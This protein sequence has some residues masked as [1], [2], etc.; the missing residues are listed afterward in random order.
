MNIPNILTIIRMA[1]IPVFVSFYFIGMPYWYGWAA[2]I[3]VIASFTDW[4]DGYLARKWN[5]VS[6]FG[7]FMDPI[8]DK[9]LVLAA[10]LVLLVW[11]KLGEEAGLFNGIGLLTVL[12][13]LS[14]E[15][16]VSGFRLVAASRGVVIAADKSGKIKTVVQMVALIL[17]LF[18]GL[19]FG[20]IGI[21][22]GLILIYASVIISVYSCIEYIVKNKKVFKE[23][24]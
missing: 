19:L 2:L 24:E 21:C 1:L 8:A 9:L 18:N 7:K 23:S 15:F 13:L 6:N 12:I 5:Q 4:L 16:I 14:R 22:L 10:L 20:R 17:L 11:G 3:F